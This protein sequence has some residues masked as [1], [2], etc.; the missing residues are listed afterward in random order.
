MGTVERFAF[1]FVAALVVPFTALPEE[2]APPKA[3]VAPVENDYFGTR[4]V[5]P[6]RWM[7]TSDSPE[8]K[9]WL[10]GQS[11]FTR[12]TLDRIEA[13]KALQERIHQL[14]QS[15]SEVYGIVRSNARYFYF[16]SDPARPVP[17]I[18]VRDGID[19]AEKL[20]LDPATLVTSAGHAEAGWFVPSS[21]GRF[22]AV[23]ISY[24]GAEEAGHLRVI[25][26]ERARL[27][28]E[29]LPQIWAGEEGEGAAWM[30]DSQSF[31]YTQ[32]PAN[33]V[34]QE[35][36]FRSQVHFHH[37]GHNTDGNGD[38]AIF[39]FGVDPQIAISKEI[40][41]LVRIP[42]A[43][44]YAI[45][46]NQTVDVDLAGVYVA[47]IAELSSGRAHWIRIASIDDQIQAN[48]NLEVHG[49]DLYM[50][51]RKGASRF[52]VLRVDL[53]HP[54]LRHAEVAV[55]QSG[56]V[57]EKI[58]AAADGLYVLDLDRG[59]SGLRHLPWGEK[60]ARAVA[61]PF[62]GSIR[63]LSTDP[64]TPGAML[65]MR[66]WTHPNVILAV[67]A[68]AAKVSDTGWQPPAKA[69]FSGVEEREVM[70]V[71]HDGT[72]IPL[73]ILVRK[74]AQLDGSHP[75]LLDS[76]GAYGVF[77]TAEPNFNAMRLAW[78]E[79]GGVFAIAHP[80]GGGEFG[81]DWHR[82]GMQLTKLNTVF[83]TIACAEY[84]VDHRYTSP[85]RLAVRGA[86]AGGI[87]VGGAIAWRPDL[88]AA[89]IDHAGESDTLRAETE[90][91]GPVNIPE[92]GTTTTPEGFHALYAMSPYQ[93]VRDGVA[94]P[95]VLLETG[96]ND[97]RVPSWQMAKMAAR[98]QAATS[99]ERPIL[100][101]VETDTGHFAG[102]TE[103]TEQLRADE[104][105]FLLWQFGDP[106]FQP[107]R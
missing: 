63:N 26:V 9:E 56:A 16:R 97:P 60:E 94:Y 83:D 18:M 92:F 43:S 87:A 8:L 50:V 33:Q 91:T 88:F 40:F 15:T 84:L 98:L 96:V 49:R 99:G 59:P 73:S 106:Q 37:L 103:Q 71:G 107:S 100:L 55:E 24:G 2:S 61:L 51:S 17:Q 20:L 25:D 104:W 47:P 101:R 19:G 5:D 78:I 44:E 64:R 82:G 57:I 13:R 41:N 90:M 7:E 35:K 80:R 48:A 102:T 32:F 42:P 93:K 46:T 81:E 54:D 36:I 62:V 31:A 86:S 52:R 6:Y 4:V 68:A 76:Y 38:P 22:V 70:A 29:D 105:A 14:N 39:G 79:R 10:K 72:L 77:G 12:R 95:A 89:A 1:F 11:D 66:G 30:P 34:E 21:D 23:G 65:R 3:R 74:G 28:D 53:A 75:A 27:L 45:A 58:A 69:D 85:K 67:D